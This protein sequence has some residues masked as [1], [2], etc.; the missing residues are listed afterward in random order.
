VCDK[1]RGVVGAEG[2]V[3]SR[4]LKLIQF[5]WFSIKL[6]RLGFENQSVFDGN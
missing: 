3:T 4:D 1:N 2:T 6:V 5:L